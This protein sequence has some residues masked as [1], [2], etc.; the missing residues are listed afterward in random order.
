MIRKMKI[1]AFSDTSFS[2]QAIMEEYFSS[3]PY[4]VIYNFPY[5]HGDLKISMPIG[6]NTV[7]DIQKQS[8]QF[9]N[10]FEN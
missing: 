1:M 7:L 2:I 3:A 4:P 6:A 8:L 5:G 10:I 9:E